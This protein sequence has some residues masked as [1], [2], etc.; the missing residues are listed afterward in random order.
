[1]EGYKV[2]RFKSQKQQ[3]SK[4]DLIKEMSVMVENLQMALRMTQMMVQN[5]D[6]TIRAI[7]SDLNQCMSMLNDIQYRTLSMLKA[8]SLDSNIIE[9]IAQQL[10]LEDY[11]S[12]SDKD[13]QAK[14]LIIS[15]VIDLQSTVIFTT[16]TPDLQEDA[17]IFRSKIMVRECPHQGLK[18]ALIGKKVG[19]KFDVEID[20][21]RHIVEIVDIRTQTAQTPEQGITNE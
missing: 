11:M 1:M 8:K 15:D 21:N 20:K 6:R 3:K 12:A 17:G 19:D 13:D 9:P 7:S 2:S 5:Q 10:K 18:D 4:G 16:T 14:G